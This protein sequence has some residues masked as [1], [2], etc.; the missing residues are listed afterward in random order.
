MR[1]GENPTR[2]RI[3]TPII[4][5][6]TDTAENITAIARFIAAELAD[7]FERW[8]L[9]AFNNLCKDKYARLGQE[10][11]FANA[12]LMRAAE[13]DE[14]LLAA[15]APLEGALLEDSEKIRWTGAVRLEEVTA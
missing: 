8:E 6:A 7:V 3:R 11:V 10:W 9:C 13:M 2:L 1:W 5:G 15:K 12:P 14:L 4:P